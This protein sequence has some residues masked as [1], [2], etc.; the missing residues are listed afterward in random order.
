[1][2]ASSLG[3]TYGMPYRHSYLDD[4]ES[5]YWLIYLSA[6]SHVDEGK[7]MNANQKQEVKLFDSPSMGSLAEYKSQMIMGGDG[8]SRWL[9]I[10]DNKWAKS[11][12]FRTVLV[13]LEEFFREVWEERDPGL[14]PTQAFTR[15]TDVLL[16]AVSN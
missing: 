8:T 15:F 3:S 9:N 6:V 13:E 11:F 7:T 12:A 1:M 10:F 2:S 4:L 14:T 5:F 16:I